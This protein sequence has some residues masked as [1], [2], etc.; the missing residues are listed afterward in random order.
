MAVDKAEEFIL[1]ASVG[2]ARVYDDA[3]LGVVV[4]NDVV[5]FRKR[6]ENE[7]FELKHCA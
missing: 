3:F 1:L 2:A 5:V 7:G 4:I 6:I